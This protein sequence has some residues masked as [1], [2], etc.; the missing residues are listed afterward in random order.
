[1]EKRKSLPSSSNTAHKV[2]SNMMPLE[3]IVHDLNRSAIG[4][5]A[6][7]VSDKDLDK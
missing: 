7:D 6:A 2:L 5:G 1:M 4:A 3:K